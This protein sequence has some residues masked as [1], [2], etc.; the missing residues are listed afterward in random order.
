MSVQYRN[1][2][3]LAGDHWLCSRYDHTVLN[4]APQSER[5]FLTLLFLSTDVWNDVMF[6]FRPVLEWFFLLRKLPDM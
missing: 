5:L 6:H 4:L 1:T 3:T 2:E